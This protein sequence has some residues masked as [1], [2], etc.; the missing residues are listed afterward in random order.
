MHNPESVQENEAPKVEN[1]DTQTEEWD[2]QTFSDFQ[3][4]ITLLLNMKL[5]WY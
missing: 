5:R 2:A 1:R 4:T 3:S